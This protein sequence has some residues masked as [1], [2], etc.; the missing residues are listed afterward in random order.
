MEYQLYI[1]EVP[2]LIFSTLADVLEKEFDPAF[3]ET[4]NYGRKERWGFLEPPWK[5]LRCCATV[6]QSPIIHI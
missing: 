6:Y 5:S 4:V 1:D 2:W 3:W